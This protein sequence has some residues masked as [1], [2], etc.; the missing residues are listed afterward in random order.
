MSKEEVI[1]LMDNFINDNGLYTKFVEYI[2]E[3]GYT[4]EEVECVVENK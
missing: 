2:E 1:A 4:P 3:K